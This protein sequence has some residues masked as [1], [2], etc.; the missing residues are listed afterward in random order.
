MPKKIRFFFEYFAYYL[1][2]Y[3]LVIF[4][5]IVTGSLIYSQRSSL[6][7]LVRDITTRPISLGSE[8][9]YTTTKPP[10]SLANL[11]SFGITT[12]SENGKPLPSPIVEAIDV[13]D[14]GLTYTIHFK[15]DLYWHNGRKFRTSDLKLNIS[16]AKTSTPSPDTLVI[17]L[18]SQFAPLLS[19]LSQPIF[20]N[21]S[22]VGLGDYKATDIVL[23]DGYLKSVRLVSV[24]NQHDW[25]TYRFYPNNTDLING[26]KLGEVNQVNSSSLDPKLAT[27]KN[28]RISPEVATD[29]YLAIFLNTAKFTDKSL[30]QALAYAT[31]KTNDNNKRCLSPI[32]P[33]SWAYNPQV[34]PYNYNPTR[35]KELIP[36][37]HPPEI[38]LLVT[39]RQ[40]LA[41]AEIIKKSW[42]DNL[43]IQVK[44]TTDT[45]QP[46]SGDFDAI[47]AYGSIPID[48]DQ[49]SFWHSTQ[50]NSNITH[51]KN[52][53][54]DK[55]LEE[56]RLKPDQLTRKQIYYDF[57]KFLLEESP[58]VF[59]EFPTNYTISRVK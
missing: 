27:L 57:Q 4:L 17:N 37:E 45:Q 32:S 35:A 25:L 29:K 11:I 55:L 21:K 22:L 12:I 46:S 52:S 7:Q 5:G 39:D 41:T 28:I 1:K 56:G 19:H 48:P 20:Y 15:N 42:Q 16:G 34:K 9:L 59:L 3:S 8:G 44:I 49:Y 18:D 24:N 36:K 31:P 54:I 53:R 47:L 10:L 30:R 26:F 13:G 38:N 51:L 6:G 58:V 50:L 40:L 2:T 43:S 23:Q 14:D 33:N